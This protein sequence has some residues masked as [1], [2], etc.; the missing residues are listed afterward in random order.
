MKRA[1]SD[2]VVD[3]L[4]ADWGRE[5]PHLDAD[6][7]Q[8]VGRILLLGRRYM[9]AANRLVAPHGLTY[10]DWDVVATLKRSGRP[11]ARS[12]EELRESVLLTS[13]A[14]TACLHRLK[15]AGLVSRTADPNDG[16][17]HAAK[18]TRKGHTLVDRLAPLRLAQAQEAV[19]VLST[20][21]RAALTTLLRQL[22]ATEQEC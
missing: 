19:A 21:Q 9:E 6:G 18:L 1:T 20:D 22:M 14:M 2:D 4:V 17:R 10:S 8:I 13:G 7:L 12:P 5:A 3:R 11:Y 16:R 15:K